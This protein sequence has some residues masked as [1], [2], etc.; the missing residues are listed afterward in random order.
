MWN[1]GEGCFRTIMGVIVYHINTFLR[2]RQSVYWKGQTRTFS[3]CKIRTIDDWPFFFIVHL[4][5]SSASLQTYRRGTKRASC[6][7]FDSNLHFSSF[8]WFCLSFVDL[9]CFPL[10]NFAS[11]GD[12]WTRIAQKSNCIHALRG[13]ALCPNR[14]SYRFSPTFTFTLLFTSLLLSCSL[15]VNNISL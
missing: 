11:H 6:Y 5:F 9:I 14:V 8:Y 12:T 10:S 15:S 4:N 1:L 7:Y 2:I 3:W 13:R